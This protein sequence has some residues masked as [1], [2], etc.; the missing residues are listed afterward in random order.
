MKT[1]KLIALIALFIVLAI[2]ITFLIY[3]VFVI[4]SIRIIPMEIEL[5]PTSFGINGD[6]DMLRFGRTALS[7]G[8]YATKFVEV[9][10]YK[11]RP[12]FVSITFS[13]DMASWV[14]PSE[15]NFVLEAG[16]IKELKFRAT[17]PLDQNLTAGN[18]TGKAKIVMKRY[19]G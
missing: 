1:K 5:H 7:V 2:S 14:E 18:Y 3:F 10:N 9:G 12:T 11:D 17:P 4:D 19:T 15:N 16:E 8:A 6:S 13:G